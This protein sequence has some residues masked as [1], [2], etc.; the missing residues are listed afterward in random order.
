MRAARFFSASRAIGG[1]EP[2]QARGD[3]PGSAPWHRHFNKRHARGLRTSRVTHCLG[4]SRSPSRRSSRRQCAGQA[5]HGR[6]REAHRSRCGGASLGQR[7]H[8]R[9][10]STIEMNG[11][12]V[13]LLPPWRA[14][15]AVLG[16]T[17]LSLFAASC[18]P[19]EDLSHP[20]GLGTTGNVICDPSFPTPH[21][22]PQGGEIGQ[23]PDGAFQLFCDSIAPVREA[24]V[25]CTASNTNGSTPTITG[26]IFTSPLLPSSIARPGIGGASVQWS[27]PLVAS[28]VVTVTGVVIGTTEAASVSIDVVARDWS[29]KTAQPRHRQT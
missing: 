13:P 18:A 8:L 24:I 14:L 27:G 21:C 2:A 25:T 15:S 5:L 9:G 7:S 3:Q 6:R 20:L 12:R 4:Q 1:E 23:S 17:C 11:V 22:T 10:T 29:T 26:W 19:A 16:A 28:G